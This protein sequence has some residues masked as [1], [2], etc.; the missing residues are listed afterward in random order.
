ML[1]LQLE[2]TAVKAFMGQI[3]REELF[4]QFEVRTID[5]IADTRINIDGIKESEENTKFIKWGA[6][7]PLIFAIIKASS[8]PKAIKIVFSHTTTEDIHPN[9]AALFLNMVYENDMVTFTTGASQREFSLGKSLDTNWDE[10]VKNF[11]K[12][13]EL[14]VNDRN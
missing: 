1:A 11:F 10:W 2:N 6:L 13:A 14:K 8:K 4:D 3:L 7:R 5:I 12:K 9:A